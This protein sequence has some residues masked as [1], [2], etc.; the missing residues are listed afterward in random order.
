MQKGILTLLQVL[1]MVYTIS[2]GELLIDDA[3][4]VCLYRL[5]VS[6]KRC[7][8]ITWGTGISADPRKELVASWTHENKVHR[9]VSQQV[10]A[11]AHK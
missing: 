11:V 8:E 9:C 6:A 3:D 10:F 2:S 4:E 5:S 7:E 1:A